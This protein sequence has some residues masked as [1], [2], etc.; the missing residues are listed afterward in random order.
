VARWERTD[1]ADP[2]AWRPTTEARIV[3]GKSWIGSL[4]TGD[5]VSGPGLRRW[6]DDVPA[7][8]HVIDEEQWQPQASTIGKLAWR[9]YQAGERQELWG[10]SPNYIRA[11]AAEEKLAS[12]NAPK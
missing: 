2:L 10:L 9:K 8:V 3:D 7:G 1:N 5:A 11:S 6:R 4:V 12:S